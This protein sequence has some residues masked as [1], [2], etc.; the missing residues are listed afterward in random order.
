MLHKELSG[1]SAVLLVVAFGRLRVPDLI[2]FLD[3]MCQATLQQL[4]CRRIFL[5]F[6]SH[7]GQV[8]HCDV[9]LAPAHEESKDDARRG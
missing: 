7:A 2:A 4:E 9:V 3:L 8:S 5:G 1:N 6:G